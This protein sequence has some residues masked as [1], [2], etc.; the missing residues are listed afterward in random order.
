MSSGNWPPR[1]LAQVLDSK[2]PRSLEAALV[3]GLRN[4][5][6]Q[7]YF[8]DL[9]EALVRINRDHLV[10]DTLLDLLRQ[11]PNSDS[12]LLAIQKLW[13]RQHPEAL[14][15]ALV[16]FEKLPG[17]HAAARSYPEMSGYA[18]FLAR[19]GDSSAL[20][21]LQGRWDALPSGIRA[22]VITRLPE[23]LAAENHGPIRSDGPSLV[24]RDEASRETALQLLI[25]ALGDASPVIGMVAYGWP[26]SPRVCDVALSSL[27][28]VE[29]E[30]F[31]FTP[32]ADM[33]K[34]D[35]ERSEGLKKWEGKRASKATRKEVEK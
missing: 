28:K 30:V 5:Q 3:A 33:T 2:Y 8:D 22:A 18:S 9:T 25:S 31:S 7:P 11:V 12:K 16:E 19:C 4:T 34:R 10:D 1:E 23:M 26:K 20:R 32:K 35:E 29:P 24:H 17:S 21:A 14:P 27:H 6:S 15:A 13:D